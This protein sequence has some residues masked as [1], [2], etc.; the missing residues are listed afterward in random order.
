MRG[1]RGM[2]LHSGGTVTAGLA[3]CARILRLLAVFTAGY[4]GA[5]VAAR[6]GVLVMVARHGILQDVQVWP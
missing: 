3:A 6:H 4:L 5:L 2:F 1:F